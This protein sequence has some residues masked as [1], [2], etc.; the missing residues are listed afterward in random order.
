MKAISEPR[1]LEDPRDVDLARHA[2]IEA[3]AG[4]GKTWT[5]ERLVARLVCGDGDVQNSLDL[6]QILVVTF[7]EK[8][9]GEMRD[10][11]RARLDELA[12]E[13]PA[14]RAHI[15]S[16]LASFDEAMITTIHGFCR[17]VLGEY[18]LEC[19]L[20]VSQELVED[21][22][23]HRSML[24]RL[25]R[26]WNADPADEA[27]VRLAG[28]TDK[29]QSYED[30][31]LKIAG[32]EDVVP[33]GDG[34]VPD[35]EVLRNL[36]Q[37]ICDDLC[38]ALDLLAPYR[39]AM[40]SFSAFAGNKETSPY[41]MNLYGAVRRLYEGL[42]GILGRYEVS[43][44][45]VIPLAEDAAVLCRIA[46][47]NIGKTA[48]ASFR[49]LDPGEQIIKKD[50]IGRLDATNSW[51][52]IIP[53][54]GE[55]ID[56]LEALRAKV[57]HVR[58]VFV[59]AVAARVR[60]LGR[61]EKAARDQYSY[62]DMIRLVREAVER[63]GGRL[64]DRLRERY[65]VAMIDEF[66]DTDGAQWAIFRTVFAESAGGHTLCLIGDP[67]QAI[68]G[69]RGGD[70]ATY[71]AATHYLEQHKQARVYTLAKNYR[72]NASMIQATS[73]LFSG[74][75]AWFCAHP[76][77]GTVPVFQK[78]AIPAEVRNDWAEDGG[79]DP[80]VVFESSGKNQD[81][82]RFSVA[83]RIADEISAI[84][85]GSLPPVRLSGGAARPLGAGDIAIL[86]RTRREAA[87]VMR[88]LRA[89]R[90]PCT[91]FKAGGLWSSPEAL[92]VLA[93]FDAL[94][95][96]SGRAIRLALA[97]PFFRCPPDALE[98][99]LPAESPQRRLLDRWRALALA[100]DWPGLCMALE[101]ES[102][103]YQGLRRDE[104]TARH[105]RSIDQ[106]DE[107]RRSANLRQIL[108]GLLLA[109]GAGE[110]GL[111]D[112]AAMIRTR[113]ERAQGLEEDEDIQPLES[114]GGK[115][116]IMTMHVA[117]GLQFPV[118]FIA[119]GFS[120]FNDKSKY[121][122]YYN[123]AGKKVI[124]TDRSG[125]IKAMAHGY[126]QAETQRLFYVALTRAMLRLYIPLVTGDTT[127]KQ[128]E[129]APPALGSAPLRGFP[130]RV[131]LESC[132]EHNVPGIC[133]A[134]QGPLAVQQKNTNEDGGTAPDRAMAALA[135]FE[136]RLPGKASFDEVIV[137]SFSGMAARCRRAD[138]PEDP[139]EEG[140]SAGE[141]AASEGEAA[142][143]KMDD[144]QTE[145]LPE[146]EA[147]PPELEGLI[148]LPRG[149]E[150]GTLVHG[151]FEEADF[152][153]A[154]RDP[155]CR[156]RLVSRILRHSRIRASR[157]W[158]ER[159][160]PG[161]ADIKKEEG[162]DQ[163][164]EELARWLVDLV[165]SVLTTPIGCGGGWLVLGSL[166]AT[167]TLREVR[168][169]EAT[170]FS[171]RRRFAPLM[172]GSIDLLFRF[173]G[174]YYVLDWKTNWLEDYSQVALAAEMDKHNYPLQAAIYGAAVRRWLVSRG[175][176]AAEFGGALYLFVRAFSRGEYAEV[177]S[178]AGVR[179]AEGGGVLCMSADEL[180]ATARAYG[181]DGEAWT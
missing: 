2:V 84:L 162:M 78:S 59:F 181:M 35:W 135:R 67:K 118:V 26:E 97:T 82:H 123:D 38:K 113:Y 69:F 179:A 166:A 74:D 18:A 87:P 157:G 49:D 124:D 164:R 90:I 110:Q 83:R 150:S 99:A 105:I 173:E 72:S 1:L 53:C 107:E 121:V 136:H 57:E 37:E 9:A 8:A 10:R 31:I 153:A 73:S 160:Y 43:R 170:P 86:V 138:D 151:L 56:R 143:L 144:A 140:L 165:E 147:D 50:W 174:K 11:I 169:D 127:K 20:P 13:E 142:G 178:D 58:R 14:L 51:R 24:H 52:G 148:C 177:R 36:V 17:S 77:G 111:E 3:S 54:L 89:R 175:R 132:R 39:E 176:S 104:R 101:R 109:P 172:T 129:P 146:L 46:R 60:A 114:D 5:I 44:G 154:G 30:V 139:G 32:A 149:V 15:E 4:T 130:L 91:F 85:A 28:F 64:T 103:V 29:P 152:Q 161:W 6:R 27:L 100:R 40:L 168:F 180:A 93:L 48:S 45:G 141:H 63:Q 145:E 98:S 88:V 117:K 137:D 156:D 79:I 106:R 128:A 116:R 23:I 75:P 62:N 95:L 155:A 61:A 7:T 22:T 21:A 133:F 94:A 47:D 119:G 80:I 65:R 102:G 158:M 19:G 108:S 66:Q 12:K 159:K 167:E 131:A 122:E 42:S 112:M 134:S 71:F 115:V 76:G 68:Y 126:W 92:A 34:M 41:N 55:V 70:V 16:R 120:D 25:Y 33:P 96:G 171:Q 163:A 81:A 125:A